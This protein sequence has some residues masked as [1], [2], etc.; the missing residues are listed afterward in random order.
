MKNLLRRALPRAVRPH[1]IKAGPLRGTCLV[2][3][4]HDYPAGILGRTER[5]L[6][7]W[8]STHAGPGDT[9]IDV[10][11]HYGYTAFALARLVGPAGRVFTFEPVAMTAGCV[12]QGRTLNGFD[13]LTVL[14]MGLGAHTT[15]EMRR[16]PLTRG[17]ADATVASRSAHA[18]VDAPFVRFDWLWPRVHGGNGTIHGIKIDVQGMELDVLEGMRDALQQWKPRVVIELHTGVSRERVIHLL[19]DVGYSGE[20]AAIDPTDGVGSARLLD[21]HS[22][23][24]NPI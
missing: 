15:L 5:P 11:A 13:Q 3:S 1:R 24:F 2:T 14:P 17:M 6:L 7:D 4:W 19:S 20:A 18:F 16:L 9:W 23:A 10:G 8:F 22:Y 21:D 12:D